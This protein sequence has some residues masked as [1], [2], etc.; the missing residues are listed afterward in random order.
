MHSNV[1]NRRCVVAC[2]FATEP[3]LHSNSSSCSLPECSGGDRR[4]FGSCWNLL[5]R[6]LCRV[7]HTHCD[8]TGIVSSRWGGKQLLRRIYYSVEKIS[9]KNIKKSYWKGKRN[10]LLLYWLRIEPYSSLRFQPELA[11]VDCAYYLRYSCFSTETSISRTD[12]MS[13]ADM[14]SHLLRGVDLVHWLQWHMNPS[15]TSVAGRRYQNCKV[16]SFRLDNRVGSA[17]VRFSDTSL[18]TTETTPPLIIVVCRGTA[19]RLLLHYET[20]ALDL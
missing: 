19:G 16:L 11:V 15:F 3:G 5:L 18:M 4:L 8:C 13:E 20:N 1:T 7:N 9:L 6:L 10:G 12:V 17:C 14:S 2:S